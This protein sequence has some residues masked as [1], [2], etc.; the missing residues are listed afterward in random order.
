[1]PYWEVAEAFIKEYGV[2]RQ[3]IDSYNELITHRIPQIIEN[4]PLIETNKEN[5]Y[6][7]LHS[8][9]ME[10]PIV[11]EAD[12]S[13]KPILPIDCRLRN[14]SYSSMIYADISILD[15]E[16][17]IDRDEVMIGKFPV[18][19]K[20]K[21]CY[22]SEMSEKELIKAKEDP[23]DQ[24]GYFIING[25]ERSLVSIENPVYNR[26]MLD[27]EKRSGQL[28][29]VSTVFSQSMYHSGKNTVRR[30]PDGYLYVEFPASPKNLNLFLLLKALGL[31]TTQKILNA[32][33]EK[34]RNDVFL[35]LE[36]VQAES[37][38]EALDQIGKRLAASQSEEYRKRRAA[39]VIDNYLLPHLGRTPEDRKTKAFYLIRMAERTIE[40]ARGE[41]KPDDKDHYANKRLKIS[42][43]LLEDLFK[44]AL[45]AFA[46]DLRYQV[47][48]AH[49]R[50]RKLQIKTLV[51]PDIFTTKVF[52]AMA[53]GNWVGGR[54][55]VSQPI[56]RH[57]YASAMSQMRR[58]RTPLSQTYPHYEAR[59][60]HPTTFGKICPVET[61]EGHNVGLQK[62][63]AIGC[64]ISSRL[65]P[66]V[67]D[68][69]K[70]MGVK[71]K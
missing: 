59:D 29:Y 18:M 47:D 48:R 30:T 19:V 36:K 64:L 35:N 26:I 38:E 15:G 7:K 11:V 24:G 6:I 5:C 65:V 8:V 22:L 42:G 37:A 56:D 44:L 69:L 68:V 1:M 14:K 61:P 51:R 58:V 53:T 71:S 50:R 27:T 31:E 10:K 20:S 21:L 2:V 57:S 55:G 40:G 45:T 9:R 70:K 43:H 49:T 39:H 54:T 12:G 41:R 32:F 13:R 60:A 46:R 28:L 63:L 4:Y 66:D 23:L 17:E 52:G 67:E 34:A 33:S 3:H 62:H 16:K 25:N